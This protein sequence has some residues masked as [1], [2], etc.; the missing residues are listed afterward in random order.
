L[1]D[2]AIKS[3]FREARKIDERWREGQVCYNRSEHN[4]ADFVVDILRAGGLDPSKLLDKKIT[5]PLDVFEAY[6]RYFEK[7]L[8]V[9]VETVAYSRVPDSQSPYK[10]TRFPLSFYQVR[11]SL[12]NLIFRNVDPIETQV[13][14][15]IAFY[16]GD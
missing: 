13:E 7:R 6:R 3:M 9:H 1:T 16:P 4:C 2:E 15:R 5:F 11:R 14:K 10:S 12:K 8:D